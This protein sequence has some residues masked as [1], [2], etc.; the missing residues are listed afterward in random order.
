MRLALHLPLAVCLSAA[1]LLPSSLA[2]SGGSGPP[3]EPAPGACAHTELVQSFTIANTLPAVTCLCKGKPLEITGFITVGGVRIGIT[4]DGTQVDKDIPICTG[5]T[6][7]PAYE[8][9]V[10]GGTTTALPGVTAAVSYYPPK[11]DQSGCSSFLFFSWGKAACD[12]MPP[13]HAG[14]IQSY[15]MTGDLCLDGDPPLP[16]AMPLA[17]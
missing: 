6:L 2:Q 4:P 12:W 3:P 7:Y 1:A 5:Y 16:V 15:F 13:Q 8:E 17:P 14:R 11:C 9:Y 10:Q